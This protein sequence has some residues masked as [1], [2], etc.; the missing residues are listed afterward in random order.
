M[1]GRVALGGSRKDGHLGRSLTGRRDQH[2][3]GPSARRV[4]SAFGCVSGG[5]SV[6]RQV[7]MPGGE[8]LFGRGEFCDPRESGSEAIEMVAILPIGD[9]VRHDRQFV[10]SLVGRSSSRLDADAGRNA[11]EDNPGDLAPAELKVE[12]GAV[13]RAPA[14]LGD[15]DLAVATRPANA[16]APLISPPYSGMRTWCDGSERRPSWVMMPRGGQA[17]LISH[18]VVPC[19]GAKGRRHRSAFLRL[20]LADDERLVAAGAVVKPAR[21]AAARRDA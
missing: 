21:G 17:P 19:S 15:Q 3:R 12:F 14:A 4:R 11:G 18:G 6:P 2:R 16:M 10:A 1:A 20:G 7:A 8:H 5:G 9:G 13:E